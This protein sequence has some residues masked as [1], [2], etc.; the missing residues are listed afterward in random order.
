MLGKGSGDNDIGVDVGT[1]TFLVKRD[2]SCMLLLEF[3]VPG[4]IIYHLLS[5]VIPF[6]Q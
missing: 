3:P 1:R 6:T 5:S 2:L 4:V